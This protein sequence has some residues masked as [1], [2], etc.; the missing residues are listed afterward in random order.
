MKVLCI[1]NNS[2]QTNAMTQSLAEQHKSI[3]HGLLTEPNKTYFNGFYHTSVY[4]MIPEKIV[5]LAENFDRVIVLDIALESWDHP[6]AFY[7]TINL[8]KYIKN[9]E[10]QNNNSRISQINYW[11]NL[12]KENKSFCIFPFIELLT[13]DA[14]T[15]VCCRSNIKIK[16]IESIDDFNND[17]DYNKI[18][19]LLLN[20][21]KIPHCVHCYKNEDIGMLSARQQ[22]TVEWANFLNLK[23]TDDLKDLNG[24]YYY[25]IRPSNTCNLQCR[26][27]SPRDSHLIEKEYNNLKLHNPSKK[28]SYHGFDIVDINKV[29]KLYVAGGE[30]T[31]MPDFFNFL[32]KCV[33]EKQTNFEILVNTNAQKV[34]NKLLSLGKNFDNL[35]Y[36][37]SIDGYKQANEYSR[38]PSSWKNTVGNIQKLINNGHQVTFN[39]TVSL[40]T[41]FS[42]KDLVYFLQENF[43]DCTIHGQFAHN[44]YPFV[45]K[46]EQDLIDQLTL[47]RKTKIYQGNNL[48]NSFIETVIDQATT[49]ICN[50]EKI[51]HFFKFNDL[52][53]KNRNVNL[54]DYI[55]ELEKLRN[56]VD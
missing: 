41:I 49:S 11:E 54:I 2:F 55:P 10:F 39:I 13:N 30:P 46:F 19:K 38:W 29:K 23:S 48:F 51:K 18:R 3:N 42:L 36:I 52:L 43:S 9:I 53:D 26:I 16:S 32:Q 5:S 37:V 24:P 4:D 40:Y 56:L 7:N 35:N 47:I 15:T 8:K 1:G 45:F 33:N 20:G 27:C 34:S 22:E 50:E 21:K 44:F 12:V 31:A 14:H 28:Y 6:T 17:K 25:E